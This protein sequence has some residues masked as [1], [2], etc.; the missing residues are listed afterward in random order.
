MGVCKG[1]CARRRRGTTR[2]VVHLRIVAPHEQAEHA[3]EL[4]SQAEN[5]C[6]IVVWEGAARRPEG[7]VILVDVPREDVSV[8]LSDLKEL[9]IDKVGAISVQ[10]IETQLSE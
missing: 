1:T 6:N 7:D 2:A 3:V 5:V 10:E 9:K 4:L 8:I